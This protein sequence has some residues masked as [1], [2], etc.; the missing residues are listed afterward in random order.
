MPKTEAIETQAVDEVEQD[1]ST[2]KKS[3]N[4]T[5]DWFR[6]VDIDKAEIDCRQF[7]FGYVQIRDPSVFA[8][9]RVEEE[10]AKHEGKRSGSHP[11]VLAQQMKAYVAKV[12]VGDKGDSGYQRAEPAP[13]ANQADKAWIAWTRNLPGRVFQRITL[14]IRLLELSVGQEKNS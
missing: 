8:L 13:E 6:W 4:K 9:A 2:E 5:P 14:A 1:E 10:S 3:E 11:D 7:G 12:T